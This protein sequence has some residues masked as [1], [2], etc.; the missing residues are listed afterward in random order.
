ML[1]VSKLMKG[2]TFFPDPDFPDF[3]IF[4]DPVLKGVISPFKNVYISY[5]AKSA[6]TIKNNEL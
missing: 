5:V 4:P 3:Q 1:L 2:G 6:I